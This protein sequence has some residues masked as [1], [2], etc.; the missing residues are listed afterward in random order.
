MADPLQATK[1]TLGALG[2]RINALT[3]EIT[4][5][6]RRLAPV[7][8]AVA[9][10]TGA[11]FGA[12]PEVAGQLLTTGGD[13]PDRLHSEAA[14]AHLCGVAPIPA[15]SRTTRRHRLNRG[16][17]RHANHAVHT[18][19]LGR[20]RHDPRTRP[21]VQRRTTEGLSK[22]EI[23]RCLN[24]YLVR[25]VYTALLAD[26]TALTGLPSI[27]ASGWRSACLGASG[28]F[29]YRAGTARPTSWATRAPRS[30]STLAQ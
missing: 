7:V 18:I 28:L 22:K 26:Y 23:M 8:A 27:G 21:Y 2:A 4:V 12:G 3:A 14:L 15:S 16:G 13:K 29:L 11:L 10:R 25:E 1:A 20:M 9:P 30:G 24:R 19:V 17:D 6:D 5:L